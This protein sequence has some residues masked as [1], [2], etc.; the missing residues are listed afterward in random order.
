M[1]RN[2]HHLQLHNVRACAI[3]HW[4]E[5]VVEIAMQEQATPGRPHAGNLILVEPADHMLPLFVRTK[6]KLFYAIYN[7]PAHLVSV[8]VAPLLWANVTP[9]PACQNGCTGQCTGELDVEV[10]VSIRFPMPPID[11]WTDIAAQ[12]GLN[13]CMWAEVPDIWSPFCAPALPEPA[14]P[15]AA[16]PAAVPTN[17]SPYLDDFESDAVWLKN[18]MRAA[19]DPAQY[20]QFYD[21]WMLKY[22]EIHDGHFPR[23]PARQFPRLADRLLREILEERSSPPD[24]NPEP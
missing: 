3:R 10:C 18:Q 24:P 16:A 15:A 23:D 13:C 20:D 12:L 11:V 6:R 1:Y 8:D 9:H 4:L 14:P 22:A 5:H 19:P 17:A 21:G 7:V 2:Y